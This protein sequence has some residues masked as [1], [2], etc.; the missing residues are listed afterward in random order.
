MLVPTG[1]STRPTSDRTREAL[2]ST[3]ETI[4]GSW[5]GLRV[6]D[7]YAGS[8]AF[9]LEAL[10]RGAAH[11]LLVDND[12]KAAA[13]L[14]RNIEGMGL[15][16]AQMR[17]ERVEHLATAPPHRPYD[18]V[19]ADPPYAVGASVVTEVMAG[20]LAAR[21]LSTDAVLAVERSSRDQPWIWP[22][23]IEAL[24]ERRYGEGTLW[25]GRLVA[26]G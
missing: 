15:P 19:L 14:R 25:Y 13:V 24:R 11:A 16:G 1:K 18:V 6:L 21:W 5:R 3:I 4:I 7:L 8:G 12:A 9:G 2:F 17:A 22:E 26:S 23:G 20:L 10:S